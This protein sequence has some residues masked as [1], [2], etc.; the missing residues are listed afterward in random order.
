[1]TSTIERAQASES[2]ERS[3]ASGV[4]ASDAAG[5]PAGAKP[6]G[7][8]WSDRAIADRGSAL[9]LVLIA[10]AL[11][12]ALGAGMV[13]IGSTEGAIAANFRTSTE[14]LYAAEAAA[15]RAIQDLQIAGTWSDVLSGVSISTFVDTLM[16]TMPSNQRVDLTALTADIQRDSDA[17]ASWGSNNPRWRLFGY[18]PLSRITGTGTVQSHAYLVSWVADDPEETDGNPL[19]DSNDRVT[20]L[21][22]AIG[23]FASQRTIEVTLVRTG[24]GRAGVR[25]VSWRVIQ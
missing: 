11:L 4:P 18:G 10:A 8:F 19:V 15:E 16:P 22:R 9:I 5:V 21:A 13:L 6:L 25:V 7:H 2:A 24:P 23:L 1:M 20:L 17:A 14:A 12:S 3:G